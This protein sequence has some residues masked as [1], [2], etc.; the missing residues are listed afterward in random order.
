MVVPWIVTECGRRGAIGGG[1]GLFWSID[2][3]SLQVGRW[4]PIIS[5][6]RIGIARDSEAA[7]SVVVVVIPGWCLSTRPGIS[8]FRARGFASPRMT[9]PPRLVD[10]GEY[11]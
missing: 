9:P 4:P 2:Y 6:R 8:R 10:P 5:G 11:G 1:R 7:S 3:F